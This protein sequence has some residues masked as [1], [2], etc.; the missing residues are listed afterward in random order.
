[1]KQ[2]IISKNGYW[3]DSLASFSSG[4][5]SSAQDW[6]LS[7]LGSRWSRGI[8]LQLGDLG[9]CWHGDASDWFRPDGCPNTLLHCDQNRSTTLAAFLRN[10]L[11]TSW[12]RQKF[13]MRRTLK[14][15]LI[16]TLLAYQRQE[17]RCLDQHILE[18][19]V[20][21]QIHSINQQSFIPPAY[22]HASC[23]S[24]QTTLQ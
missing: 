9:R 4:V 1:M 20:S 15:S 3:E 7:E 23:M 16:F 8:L 17:V 11:C 13:P 6:R 21:F 5:R 2:F 12:Q 22:S 14:S 24:G 10:K 19:E 18:E